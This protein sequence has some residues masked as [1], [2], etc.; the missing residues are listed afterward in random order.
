MTDLSG[1]QQALGDALSGLLPGGFDQH[2]RLLRLHTPLGADA[3]LAE[4]ATILEG[5]VPCERQPAAC[6]ITLQALSTRDDIQA[7]ELLGQPVHLEL[8]TAS[9]AWRPFHGHVTRFA[10]L[11]SDGG[12]SRYQLH[13]EPWL[14]FLGHRTDAWV[15]QDMS[16][17]DITEAVF[18][19][20]QAQGSL[21]P[22][23]RIDV[24]DREAFPRRS[25]CAQ[26]NE[27]D[28][29]FLSRLWAE[30]GLFAWF[31]HAP[32]AHTL[33]LADHPGAFQDNAQSRIRYTQAGATLR[34]DSLQHWE[35]VR[36]VGP[37]L[38][39][40]AS[41]DH[42][43]VDSHHAQEQVAEAHGQP[44]SL[45]RSDQ[46]GAYA[47]GSPAQAQRRARL[48]REAL[49]ARRKRFEGAG[50][51]R[52]LAPGTTFELHDHAEHSSPGANRFVVLSVTHTA[53]NNLGFG[54]E[55]ANASDEPL[56]EA[57]LQAQRAHVPVRLMPLD[58]RGRPAL[59]K[60][61]VS[62]TQTALV[63]G[64]REP[65][66]TDRD[67]RIKVQ[68]HW[69]RGAQG[70]HRLS[71]P[72]GDNAPASDASGTWVRV[73]QHWA[74]AN[75][76]GAFIPRLGQE[77]VVTF[78]EGDI[79]R[80]VVIGAAYNGQGQ[81]NAAGNTV[82]SGA[83]Q[84]TGNAPAWFPGSQRHGQTE[85]HAH[86]ATLSGFH[87]QSLDSSQA[88]GGGHNQIVMDDTGS[89]GRLMLHTT[90][91]QTWLQMG[92]LLQQSG[93][94]R[95]QPRGHGLELHTQA[96]G[97]LRAGRGLHLSTHARQGGT[98]ARAQPLD[99][100]EA[101][102]QLQAHAEMLQALHANAQTHR[103]QLPGEAAP[104]Q[105]PARQALA[106][107]LTSLQA[108]EGGQANDADSSTD[109]SVPIGGGQG[110]IDTS[111]RPDLILS[112]CAD[113]HAATPAHSVI[114]CGQNVTLTTAQDANLLAQRHQAWA[115]KGGI[116]L[117]TRGEAKGTQR[118]VQ[119]VGIKLHAASGNVRTEAQ[120]G[121]FKLTA[122]KA[123]DLQSTAADI[124]ITA[125][126]RI[127]LNGGGGYL[128]IEGGN[129]EIGTSG[130][131]TFKGAA[132]ELAGGGSA[133][134]N[135]PA[136]DKAQDLFDEQFAITDEHTGEALPFFKYRIENDAGEV[137]AR[138]F[139]DPQGKT[140]RIHTAK[141]QKI[142]VVADDN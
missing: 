25:L 92:H 125:P 94:Q 93:N 129:I 16:V 80:P 2:T 46:P 10:H 12:F 120:S 134:G 51:V 60:P 49:E 53:R 21:Q 42:R 121:P 78:I 22:A 131:A 113:I 79:D 66:H 100:R 40:T 103:A 98:T 140:S 107:T 17:L 104:E 61:H 139:T 99:T 116:S 27:S 81:D 63:V 56:Y 119:D 90:Q 28:L 141:G 65:V 7:T 68:F 130:P 109:G 41:W 87:S 11:G 30:E 76:G 5:L 8:L 43:Q 4:R 59:S 106:A 64:L 83:A 69:Q 39:H 114:A 24:A 38:L 137:L 111:G 75:W 118:G 9:G 33:V 91:A 77:V 128:K 13:I 62:G 29:A 136:L 97:A 58:A 96:Q 117:F 101:E 18:A 122:Q 32:D 71:P 15:F 1:I 115:V 54:G 55:H 14:S 6:H 89:Q 73:A 36:R 112:A 3:L 34:E 102:Q 142:R 23:W 26:F 52:T 35:G 72:A 135:G 84:A 133:S 50:T 95:L 70:S 126:E 31:E 74:G 47:H 37:S 108:T 138:G 124:V 20:H 127:V 123:V 45:A 44:F 105:L 19:D 86:A 67:G 88:G 85:G 82:A 48:Q 132:K 57:R 110:R